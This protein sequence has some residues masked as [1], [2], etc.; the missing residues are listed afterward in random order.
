[1]SAL[2]FPLAAIIGMASGYVAAVCLLLAP[3]I[4]RWWHRRRCIAA[5]A[6]EIAR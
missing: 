2:P 5:I 4:L 6:R 3:K 1:M